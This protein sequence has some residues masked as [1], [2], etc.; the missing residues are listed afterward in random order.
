[1]TVAIITDQSGFFGFSPETL[2]TSVSTT[3]T[4]KNTT[5]LLSS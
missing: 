3:V 5:S 2:T 1:M 4:W